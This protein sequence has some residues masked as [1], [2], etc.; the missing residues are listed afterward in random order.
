LIE[1]ALQNGGSLKSAPE[2][3]NFF[4]GIE[5][6]HREIVQLLNKHGIEFFGNEGEDFD[7]SKHE[8]ISQVE[9]ESSKKETVH[10]VFQKGASYQGRLLT[11]AKVIVAKPASK[12]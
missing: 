1:K 4:Q 11:P 3:K 7:P 10:K 9:S 2:T 5:M 12:S 8:A 6:I